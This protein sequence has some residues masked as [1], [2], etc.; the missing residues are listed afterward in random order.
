MELEQRLRIL[1]QQI[2]AQRR[3]VD[4]LEDRIDKHWRDIKELRSNVSKAGGAKRSKANK[5]SP[6]KK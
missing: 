1:E 2:D 3:M 4:M 6:K 5:K